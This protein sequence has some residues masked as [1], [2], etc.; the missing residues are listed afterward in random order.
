MSTATVSSSIPFKGSIVFP[1][2]ILYI[3]IRS[4]LILPFSIFDKPYLIGLPLYAILST[5]LI[6]LVVLLC[7]LSNLLISCFR[8]LP[9]PFV[10]YAPWTGGSFL[11]LGLGQPW[12]CLDLLPLLP[13]L[14]GIA[15]HL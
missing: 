4:S 10:L 11:S 14:F 6:I 5:P 7:I 12:P 3:F 13:L 1:V 9:H 8:P 15:I 2:T